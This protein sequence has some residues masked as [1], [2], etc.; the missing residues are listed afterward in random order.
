MPHNARREELADARSAEQ[1]L[2]AFSY[3]VSHDLAAS[4]RHVSEFSR[5]LLCELGDGLTGRQRSHADHIRSATEK[6]Q[7]MMEQLLLFSRVQQ[8]VLKP[9]RQDAT[10]AL[11]LV[12]AQLDAAE[13][14]GAEVSIEPLGEVFADSE[15]LAQVFRDL[16]ENAL[17][18]RRSGA[19]HRISISAG[20]DP[21]FW[22]MR[23]A[24]NGIGV[25]AAYREKAFQMFQR[26]NGEDAYSGVGAGLTIARRIARRQ[27]G[28]VN[29]LDCA[30]GACVEL[31]LPRAPTLQ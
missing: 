15:L 14:A 11:R 29:F 21:A 7:L 12:I 1:E 5:L 26:L 3:I 17:K 20:H 22:R 18:F 13:V 8:R 30:D 16:L 27:G 24:D 6:C 23:I 28:D 31:S 25:E 2:Q 9:V 10:P 4:F 19:R